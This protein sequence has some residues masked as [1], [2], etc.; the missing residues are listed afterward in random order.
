MLA[1]EFLVNYSYSS[2]FVAAY[3]RDPEKFWSWDVPYNV[4]I[5]LVF[6]ALIFAKGRRANIAVLI[7]AII[8]F[9]V[10]YWSHRAGG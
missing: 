10:P 9:F 6:L 4:I 5:K 2:V 8:L 3:H 1:A 7:V